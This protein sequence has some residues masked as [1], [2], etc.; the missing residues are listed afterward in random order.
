[1]ESRRQQTNIFPLV[2]F[3]AGLSYRLTMVATGHLPLGQSNN[4]SAKNIFTTASNPWHSLPRLVSCVKWQTKCFPA[5][6]KG[7]THTASHSSESRATKKVE[8]RAKKGEKS[9]KTSKKS[10]KKKKNRGKTT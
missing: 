4:V 6:A 9:R 7:P 10:C 2:I 5:A 1:M 8:K 3:I